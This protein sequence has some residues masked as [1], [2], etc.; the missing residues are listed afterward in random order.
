MGHCIV[1]FRLFVLLY[2]QT[3][4]FVAIAKVVD[5]NAFTPSRVRR[6]HLVIRQGTS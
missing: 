6:G 5:I 1:A 4:N 3:Q 2:L